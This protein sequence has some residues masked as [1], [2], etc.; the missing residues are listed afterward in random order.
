MWLLGNS[1]WHVW[2]ALYFHET[3]VY[4]MLPWNRRQSTP[5]SQ[6]EWEIISGPQFYITW[7]L[8]PLLGVDWLDLRM[9]SCASRSV[10]AAWGMC[11][12]GGRGHTV[13]EREGVPSA[14]GLG[15]CPLQEEFLIGLKDSWVEASRAVDALKG[16]EAAQEREDQHTWN[17]PYWPNW[18]AKCPVVKKERQ[19]K[20]SP[21]DWWLTPR[22]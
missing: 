8:L 5:A 1:E 9:A 2:L 14:P 4:G 15:S 22:G 11:G 6:W 21:L 13:A 16:V 3:D 10:P 18:L 19:R 7:H 20:G 12:E 17:P